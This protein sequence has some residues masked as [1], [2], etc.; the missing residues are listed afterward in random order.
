M[1]LLSVHRK[2]SL[3]SLGLVSAVLIATACGSVATRRPTK[4]RLTPVV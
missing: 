1:I 2:R 4:M 3:A